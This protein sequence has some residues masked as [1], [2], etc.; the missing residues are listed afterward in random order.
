MK[1]NTDIENE[2][3]QKISLIKRTQ[4]N[5]LQLQLNPHFL[6]NT[7]N[8]I[9]LEVISLTGGNNSASRMISLLSDLL[10]SA[11]DTNEYFVSFSDEILY[12]EKYL[13][14]ETIKYKNCFDVVWDISPDVSDISVVKF[15]LQPIIENSIRHGILK[16]NKLRRGILKLA[17]YIENDNLIIK[18]HDNGV[19]MTEDRLKEVR[20]NLSSNDLPNPQHIGLCNVNQ[21]IKLHYGDNYGCSIDSDANG[22]IVTIVI[23]ISYD[24]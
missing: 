2:L 7:L 9:S 15:V 8:S 10:V 22:T 16:L 1:K 5:A 13:R 14:I 12:T 20:N 17:A 24:I 11:L 18:I 3:V 23:P 19:G 4:A 6:F 21:R